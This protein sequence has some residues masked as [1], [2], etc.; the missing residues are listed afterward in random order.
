MATV[1]YS[2][3]GEGRGHAA[4]AQVLVELLRLRHRVILSASGQALDLLGP[5]YARTDVEVRPIEGLRFRYD[6]R[7][8]LDR[9]ASFFAALPF[10]AQMD[11]RARQLARSLERDGVALAIADFEPLLPRAAELANVPCMSVDHQQF[12]L[13]YDL[14]CLP[15]PL[16]RKAAFLAPFTRPFYHRPVRSVV[17]AFFF[18]PLRERRHPVTQAGVLLRQ[19]VLGARPVP[20]DHLVAYVRREAPAG[21]LDALAAA[22]RPV[23]V[24]GHGARPSSGNLRFFEIEPRR[25]IE[26]LA[27]SAALVS[28]AG[29]QVVGEALFLKKPVLAYPEPGNFEQH[30][31]AFFL[32]QSRCGWARDA[33]AFA[34]SLVTSFLEAIPELADHIRPERMNGNRATLAAVEYEVAAATTASAVR[35]DP[36]RL[37]RLRPARAALRL[38]TVARQPASGL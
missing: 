27:T 4:R 38:R 15:E 17:S 31:N 33:S 14:S 7:G 1:H 34:P 26:D 37:P 35:S 2:M 32:E 8:R 11:Q 22:G 13:S 21:V 25:F 6:R 30:I 9:P 3:S 10:V 18:P 20:G 36:P 19:D 12:L 28:T 24:Y 16:R 29:N 5:L 23:H